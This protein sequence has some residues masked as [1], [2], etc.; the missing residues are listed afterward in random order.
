MNPTIAPPPRSVVITGASG[1]LGA[2]TAREL[3]VRPEW[4]VILACR[5][6]ARADTLRLGLQRIAR[7]DVLA[8]QLDLATLASIRAFPDALASTGAAPLGALVCNAGVQFVSGRVDTVDGFEA[9]F[10]VNHLGHFL[11]TRL[12]LPRLEQGGVV[13][14]VASDTHD[15]AQKTG[16]PDPRFAPAVELA[17]GRETTDDHGLAGRTRYTTSKLCNVLFAYE[18]ARRLARA[19]SP[20]QRSLRVLAVD[21]GLMPGTGLA[22]DYGP[23][24]RLAWSFLLPVATLFGSNIHTVTTS[25]RA[26]ARLLHEPADRWPSGIYV[27]G[28]APKRSSAASY[29]ERDALELWTGSSALLGLPD[30]LER[31]PPLA[32]DSP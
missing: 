30:Q 21:P 4:Q 3:A 26:L 10:G 1:G 20:R 15:P 24:A 13:V 14:V 9:T 28:G 29:V 6:P 11:L 23:L 12:L 19:D 25:A 5:D 8:L 22:R 16:M 32:P 17:R 18:L 27:S 31:D 7:H 2:A